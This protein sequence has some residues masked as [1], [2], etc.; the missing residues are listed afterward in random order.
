MSGLMNELRERG[1]ELGAGSWELGAGR[2]R[3]DSRKVDKG[4][5]FAC[6]VGHV[7]DGHD[8]AQEAF[9]RGAELLIVERVLD[10][11]VQQVLVS[12]ARKATAVFAKYIYGNPTDKFTLIGVTG[13]NGKSTTTVL[14]EQLCGFLGYKTGLIGTLGYKIGD[15]FYPTERTT[16]DIIE[17]NEIFVKMVE[18]KCDVVIME[19]SSHALALERVYSLNYKIG[20]FT[21]LSQDHLDFHHTMDKYGEA[22]FKLFEM[23]EENKGLNI[24][25]TDDECGKR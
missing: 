9:D 22:K 25:N 3:T 23:V 21:N 19:V 8:F 1:L 17:L 20:V 10:I 16:P 2:L 6:I 4:D 15:S 5:I 18:A 13:T 7:S 14:I 12:D 11:P 24:I